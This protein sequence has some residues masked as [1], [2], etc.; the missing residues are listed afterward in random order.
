MAAKKKGPSVAKVEPRA[1]KIGSIPPPVP[2]AKIANQEYMLADP[3][4][5]KQHPKNPKKG[6]VA[7]IGESIEANRFYGA[8]LVQKSTGFILAG[9]HRCK[10]ALEKGLALVPVIAIDCDDD[11]AEKILLGDNRIADLGSYDDRM[12]MQ[13]LEDQQKRGMSFAGT[14]YQDHDLQKLMRKYAAPEKFPEVVDR[15]HLTYCCP[16]CGH[17]WS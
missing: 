11:T 5:L 17:K 1:P 3:R 7:A 15:P 2:E 10:S 8:I 14:G 6:N 16:A 4:E 13:I 9:N 12:L